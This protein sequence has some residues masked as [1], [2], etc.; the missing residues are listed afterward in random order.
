MYAVNE[1]TIIETG[2]VGSEDAVRHLAALKKAHVLTISDTHGHYGV[3]ETIV[4]EYGPSCD[5]LLF[6]GD[7]MWDVVQYLENS[8]E[9]I[10]L[11]EALP[12]VVAFVAGNGDGGSY[13]FSMSALRER[14]V[15]E[16]LAGRTITVPAYQVIRAAGMD[17]FLTH[18]HRY[19]VDVSP[20]ILV[21]AARAKDCG[22]AMYGHTHF[23][24]FGKSGKMYILN[25]GSAA[26]PRGN[27]SAG[28]A[29]LSIDSDNPM[30]IATF[31]KIHQSQLGRYSIE[32]ALI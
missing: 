24:F 26:R 9:N 25:P 30:P 29:V 27:S 6:S 28:F 11:L 3:F 18:G 12:P 14:L 15:T 21:E 5:A 22:I 16:V 4:K 13:R 20:E 32:S 8:V 2:L 19:S 1:L 31:Y 10:A 23:P 17:V 7:G